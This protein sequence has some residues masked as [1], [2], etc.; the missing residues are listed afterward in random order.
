M[1]RLDWLKRFIVFSGADIGGRDV[2]ELAAVLGDPAEVLPYLVVHGRA[3][4]EWPKAR[5]ALAR[6]GASAAQPQPRNAEDGRR[7]G[8]PL[9]R[10]RSGLYESLHAAL[11]SSEVQRGL[12]P[13]ERGLNS[14]DLLR[15]IKRVRLDEDR[16]ADSPS[17]FIA[18][19]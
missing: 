6:A 17:M 2:Q 5:A 3:F 18:R 19:D 15:L 7:R 12:E 4:A 9:S 16:G 14:E 1:I 8:A 11:V 13:V 10:I